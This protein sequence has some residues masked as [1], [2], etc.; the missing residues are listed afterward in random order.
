MRIPFL[1]WTEYDGCSDVQNEQCKSRDLYTRYGTSSSLRRGGWL[2][3]QRSL[4]AHDSVSVDLVQTRAQTRTASEFRGQRS[5]ITVTQQNIII[6]IVITLYNKESW[7]NRF[8]S[9][10]ARRQANIQRGIH[11]SIWRLGKGK[12]TSRSHKGC[13]K[14]YHQWALIWRQTGV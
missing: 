1:E 7:K 9:K 11:C 6:I 12:T 8:Y 2:Q 5:K 13:A 10:K 4:W 14:Y 3:V